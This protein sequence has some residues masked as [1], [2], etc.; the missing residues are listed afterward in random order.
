[1]PFLTSGQ[2]AEDDPLLQERYRSFGNCLSAQSS[3]QLA[4]KVQEKVQSEM[5][6][7]LKVINSQI[8]DKF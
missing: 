6:P 5:I 2:R 7:R 1:M 4:V 8:V 3:E